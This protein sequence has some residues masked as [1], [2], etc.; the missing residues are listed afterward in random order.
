MTT[1]CSLAAMYS[2]RAMPAFPLRADLP[3]RSAD[4]PHVRLFDAWQS[5]RFDQFRYPRQTSAHIGGQRPQLRVD[6]LI[7]RFDGPRHQVLL[8]Q[9]WY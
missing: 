9:M 3:D 4:M 6:R 7:H 8:Y 1:R 2:A 5:H